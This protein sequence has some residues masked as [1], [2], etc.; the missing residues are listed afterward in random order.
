MSVGVKYSKISNNNDRHV[1]HC[2]VTGSYKTKENPV[3]SF[4]K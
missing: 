1:N 2:D 3:H 4:V